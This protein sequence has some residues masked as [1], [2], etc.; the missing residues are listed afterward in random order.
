MASVV[1]LL[2]ERELAA[3]ERVEVLRAEADRVLALLAEAET[4][5]QEWVIARQRVGEVLSATPTAPR[6]PAVVE[7]PDDVQEQEP[8]PAVAASVGGRVVPVRQPGSDPQTLPEGYREI[9][10]VVTEQVG[11]DGGS[12]TG[13][14]EIAAGLG[15]E[16]TPARV[17]AVRHRAKRLV[18]RGWLTEPVPGRFTFP[19][20]RGAGS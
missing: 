9:M 14:Q 11:P 3:R 16:P 1:G 7:A 8:G 10:R 12:A 17:E 15:L 6:E 20:G 4:G 19:G 2:E 5:W 18:T 13:C